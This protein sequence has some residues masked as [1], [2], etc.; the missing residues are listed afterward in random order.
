MVDLDSR[1]LLEEVYKH[2]DYQPCAD[3]WYIIKKE[4]M[5]DELPRLREKILHEI[6]RNM[7]LHR[8]DTA[9]K[10]DALNFETYKWSAHKYFEDFMIALEWNRPPKEKFYLPRQKVLRPLVE[11]L[12]DLADDRLDELFLSMP[13]RVGKTT[14]TM[15][16]ALWCMARD[17]DRSNLYVSYSDVITSAFYGGIMEIVTDDHTYAFSEIFPD[18]ELPSKQNGMQNAKEETIDFDR[19]KRYHS[20]TCRSLYG[21]LNGACDCNGVLIAD[22]LIGSIEEAMNKD[23]LM[24][25]WAKV[26]NN[27]IPRAKEFAKLLWVG[28]RWSVIDPAGLRMEILEN[29]EQFKDRRYR[30]I[31]L[32]AL[33][34]NDESNFDYDYGVGYS[35]QFY[36]QRRSSFERTGDMPSWNA[37]YMCMPVEREGTVFDASEMRFYNGELPDEEPDRTFMV[38][39]PAWGGG[40]YV[41]SP[42]CLQYGED[43]YVVDVVYS[44]LDKTK[45]QPLVF[46]KAVRWGIS[47]I[48]VEANRTQREYADG[49]SD[50]AKNA[51]SHITVSTKPAPTNIGKEQRIFDKAPDIKTHFLFLEDGKR[52]KEYSMFMQNVYSFKITGKNKHDDA[53]DSLSQAADYAFAIKDF[54]LKVFRRLWM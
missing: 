21:T 47:Q 11:A 54:S 42:V 36:R 33:D 14:M 40:D 26:E 13:P 19:A 43:I 6:Q 20:I 53:P 50:I 27:M 17:S 38:V 37:Q 10:L 35:T 25:A 18:I 2:D 51:G 44:N 16:F 32:P 24:G 34:D 7:L 30:I 29:D 23:R 5:Y 8:T 9:A 48:Q 41:A 15:F 39:D 28:T 3:A 46:D 49:I 1:K 45:T 22:D 52:T 31:N 4:N 12:Q